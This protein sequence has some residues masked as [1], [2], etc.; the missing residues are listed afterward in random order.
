MFTK[1]NRNTDIIFLDLNPKKYDKIKGKK[2]SIILSP[3]FYWVKKTKLPIKY[4]KDAKKLLAS[5]FEDTLPDGNYSYYVYKQEDDFYIFAYED[6]HILQVINKAGI[7]ISDIKSIHFAQSEMQNVSEAKKVNDT[8]SICIKDDVV[9]L[10]PN[11]WV[12]NTKELNFLDIKLS[13]HKIT[14]QQYA[15]I[16]QNKSLYKIASILILFC[17]IVLI[18]YFITLQKTD[19]ITKSKE[20]LFTQYQ[21]KPTMIQNKSI[22]NKY[23]KIYKTQTKLRENI[24]YLLQLKLKTTQKLSMLSIKN[25]VLF[26]EISGATKLTLSSM[27]SIFKAKKLNFK[28]KLKNKTLYLEISL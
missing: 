15:H 26:A 17:M 3:S 9:V 14:L 8:Q 28:A 22:L 19:K 11:N 27:E 21:L 4:I 24:F 6:K 10:V 7:Q 23:E 18:E 16:V 12:K 2:V 20:S 13:K 1:F 5:L 25:D